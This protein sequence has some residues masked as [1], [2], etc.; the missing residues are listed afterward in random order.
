MRVI[1]VYERAVPIS[2]Y[3]DPGI[4]SGG[5]NTTVV[6]IVTDVYRDGAPGVGF[7]FSSIGRFGQSGLIRISDAAVRF[8]YCFVYSC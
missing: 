8:V 1:D 2:R 3:S 6:A 5:L 7:G 4:P